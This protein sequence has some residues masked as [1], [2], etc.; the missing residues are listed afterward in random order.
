M[1]PY[2]VLLLL[3]YSAS[4]YGYD[5]SDRIYKCIERDNYIEADSLLAEWQKIDSLNPELE[6]VKFNRF[7]NE[8]RESM[9]MLSDDISPESDAMIFTDSLG[10]VAGSIRQSLTW[11][12]ELYDRALGI[13]Q[14]A[15]DMFP[16]RLDMRFGYATSLAMRDRIAEQV[17]VLKNVLD[18]GNKIGYEWL[19][20][21]DEPL[22]D[23]ETETVECIWDSCL[24]IY[25]SGMD[26][27]AYELCN[28]TL[29]FFPE[30]LRFINMCGAIKYL[31]GSY[32][33]ALNYFYKALELSPV[34][35]IV[36]SNIAQVNFAGGNFDETIRFCDKIISITD[37]DPEI[38]DFAE[39]LREKAIK[40]KMN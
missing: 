2:F 17:D 1:R 26:S 40:E 29:K 32:N 33:E 10:N 6:I 35:T 3:L 15:I 23:P 13:I 34:D 28:E 27:L 36:M 22:A 37:G 9:L 31:S 7:L 5:F 12:D 25:N 30:D 20:Q 14:N 18:Y 19:W 16:S 24:G 11:N 4:L 38:F 39:E 8:S 21:G